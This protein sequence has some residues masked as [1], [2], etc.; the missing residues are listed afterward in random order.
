MTTD[1]MCQLFCSA[2]SATPKEE[3][4]SAYNVVNKK[5]IMKRTGPLVLS[6]MYA[7]VL[8]MLYFS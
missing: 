1:E 7:L 4:T 6:Y 3:A 2:K 5:H 8:Q